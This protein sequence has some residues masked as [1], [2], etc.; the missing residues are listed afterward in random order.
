MKC[1]MCGKKYKT[2]TWYDKHWRNKHEYGHN[3]P[4]VVKDLP[5]RI[6]PVWR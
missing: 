4:N 3:I 6:Y 1:P 5:F 2:K